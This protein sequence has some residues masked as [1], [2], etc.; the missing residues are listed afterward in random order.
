MAD[1]TN[2][3][4][5]IFYKAEAGQV[6]VMFCHSWDGDADSLSDQVALR[7]ARYGFFVV[8]VGMRGRNSADGSRDASGYEIYDVYDA[9]QYVRSNY[10]DYCHPTKAVV[11][12]NSGGGGNVLAAACK[13]PDAWSCVVSY[14][15]M[16][17]YG[18]D[19][20]D[21]WYYQ[22][23]AA[24]QAE[25]ET[26]IG[27]DPATVP[28][29][30]YARDATAAI[31]NFPDGKIFLFHDEDDA[32]VPIVHS[33]R[34]VSA[35]NGAGLSN[36]IAN[37]TDASDTIRWTHG[38]PDLIDAEQIWKSDALNNS[39]WTIATSGTVTVIGYIVTKRFTIWL[40][41]N[42]SSNYGLDAV[43]TVVYDTAVDSYIVTPLTG[44]I[45]ALITQG[46]KTGSDTNFN[47]ETV[48]IVS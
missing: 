29:N 2:L 9:L 42:G 22:V 5:K 48:I 47:S 12:G 8:P 31:T 41:A 13:F 7:L 34:V 6:P 16:S 25:L 15:G 27:N 11:F 20:P 43:A 37:F 24:A 36:Y 3:Y 44:S 35:L 46:A 19:N 14:F 1:I 18:R 33:E 17:D 28:N 21:G 38:G 10:A 32:V 30:Y 45:D 39:A 23:G 4:T 40:R 26:A